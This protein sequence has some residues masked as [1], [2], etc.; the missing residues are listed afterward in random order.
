MLGDVTEELLAV[1]T[2]A[3]PSGRLGPPGDVGR[4][5]ASLLG[6]SGDFITGQAIALEGGWPAQ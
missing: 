4:L 3:T 5:I 6:S 1:V 2:S